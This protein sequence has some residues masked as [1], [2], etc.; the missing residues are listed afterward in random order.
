ME[1][2]KGNRLHM[3]TNKGTA[4][5]GTVV[6]TV[7]AALDTAELAY[8]GIALYGGA[9]TFVSGVVEWSPDGNVWG[10]LDATSF[11]A[12]GATLVFAYFAEN[13]PGRYLRVRG[14]VASGSVATVA[15]YWQF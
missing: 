13:W 6:T 12:Q 14:A 7:A 10:T 5:V 1:G 11:A 2:G 3:D 8:K 9:A 4:I 15:Y